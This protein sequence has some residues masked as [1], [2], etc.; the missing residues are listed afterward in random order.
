MDRVTVAAQEAVMRG[1]KRFSVLGYIHAYRVLY[2]VRINNTYAPWVADEL[3][4]EHPELLEIIER[5]KRK[6]TA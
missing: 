2:R 6:V 3:V 1:D 4:R 5:R